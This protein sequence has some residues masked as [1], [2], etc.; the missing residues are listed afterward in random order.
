MN[1]III[2][3]CP[4]TGQMLFVFRRICS[5]FRNIVT[6]RR[7][8]FFC[9]NVSESRR[10]VQFHMMSSVTTPD[11]PV[12]T[13]NG[14]T[15]T[16]KLRI[17]RPRTPARPHKKLSE[18][19]LKVRVTDTKRRLQILQSKAVLMQDRLDVYE[20]EIELRTA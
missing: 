11:L 9:N 20:R 19:V 6:E 8:T 1:G 15:R 18:D 10:R 17:V 13:T 7:G 4:V 16:P 14:A 3:D 12:E 5:F 2:Y